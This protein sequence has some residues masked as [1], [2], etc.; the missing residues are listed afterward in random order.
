MFKKWSDR[1]QTL[2]HIMADCSSSDDDQILELSIYG[3]L[4]SE[5]QSKVDD[6]DLLNRLSELF[7][8]GRTQFSESFV[9]EFI[10]FDSPTRRIIGSRYA[11]MGHIYIL[12]MDTERSSDDIYFHQMVGGSDDWQR[13]DNYA[14]AIDQ[15]DIEYLSLINLIKFN[16]S[17]CTEIYGDELDRIFKLWG[18]G[19]ITVQEI[20]SEIYI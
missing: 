18:D 10:K 20:R 1:Y 13:E 6:P 16:L 5:M 14:N 8:T 15:K 7:V 3:D 12:A 2:Q 11:G 19:K 4:P 17:K 9:D